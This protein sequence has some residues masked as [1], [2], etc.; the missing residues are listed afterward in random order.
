MR[1][2]IAYFN[3]GWYAML[4]GYITQRFLGELVQ[5]PILS[6][7]LVVAVFMVFYFAVLKVCEKIWEDPKSKPKKESLDCDECPKKYT[8]SKSNPSREECK[9]RFDKEE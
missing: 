7:L 6:F 1:K 2:E 5:N 9:G 3:G 4:F 8:C